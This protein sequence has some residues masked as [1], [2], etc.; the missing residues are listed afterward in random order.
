MSMKTIPFKND[1]ILSCSCYCV[2]VCVFVCNL[3]EEPPPLPVSE[4]EVT[5]AVPLDD[6][7]GCQLLLT[8]T[9]SPEN[10]HIERLDLSVCVEMS[11]ITSSMQG[12]ILCSRPPKTCNRYQDIL[13]LDITASL[14]L[15]LA[16]QE[17]SCLS[18]EG[19][20]DDG[21]FEISLLLQLGQNSCPEEH[22]TLTNTIQ[23]C[24]QIKVLYLEKTSGKNKS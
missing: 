3:G 9:E 20:D 7:H 13:C 21:Q 4:F 16:G 5:G 14:F 1:N 22:F 15:L 24:I 12:V 10:T 8:F 19:D 23:V 6:L 17:A 2:C 18:L 11:D